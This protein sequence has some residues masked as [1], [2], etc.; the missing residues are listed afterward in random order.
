MN[1]T[2]FI[3]RIYDLL[4]L[5]VENLIA[6]EGYRIAAEAS[7]YLIFSI[8]PLLFLIFTILGYVKIPLME[9]SLVENLENM[10]SL[11]IPQTTLETVVNNLENMVE[12]YRGRDIILGALLFLWPA[13]NVFYAYADAVGKAYSAESNRSYLQER[14]LSFYLL[15]VA[16]SIIFLTSIAFSL[17]PL[18]IRV[19]KMVSSLYWPILLL[20]FGRY[21]ASFLLITP[22]L[23]LLYRNGPDVEDKQSLTVW[24]GAL[25]ATL[26]W[27]LFAQLFGI[28]LEYMDTYRPL[29]GALGGA[30]LLLLW[31]YLVSLAIVLGAEFNFSLSSPNSEANPR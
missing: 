17:T 12:Q 28:Y 7:F 22:C 24:P 2:K 10:L 11:Y 16:G 26:L 21:L 31:M 15:F 20:Q 19:M 25:F 1:V 9:L 23:V 3:Q 13:S 4:K 5:T 30:M 14:L 8:F 27:V 6:D 29:Y 18:L